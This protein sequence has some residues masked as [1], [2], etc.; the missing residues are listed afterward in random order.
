M[1]TASEIMA[2]VIAALAASSTAADK[3]L[4]IL[5]ALDSVSKNLYKPGF[6]PAE[7]LSYLKVEQAKLIE[8]E[9]VTQ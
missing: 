5:D 9:E 8:V 2:K 1:K 7:L 3:H 6:E 4:A